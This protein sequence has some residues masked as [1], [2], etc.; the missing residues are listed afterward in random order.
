ML[1]RLRPALQCG[2]LETNSAE[3]VEAGETSL[4]GKLK[5]MRIDNYTRKL[6]QGKLSQGG[7]FG[8]AIAMGLLER[9]RKARV[10]VCRRVVSITPG[11]KSAS[12]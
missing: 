1:H 2:S 12:M 11:M 6:A 7:S 5:N 3:D 4:G 8:T 9:H 10:K